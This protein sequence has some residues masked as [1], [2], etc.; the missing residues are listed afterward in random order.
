M[1]FLSGITV[2]CFIASYGV[3]LA[4]EVV[5]L[6]Y[7]NPLR[8][9]LTLAFAGAG[10]F[11]HTVFLAHRAVAATGAPLSSAFDWYLLAAWALVIVYLYLAW[12]YPQMASGLFVL[13][14]VLGLI[15]VA[16]FADREPFPQSHAGQIWGLI[17]G[18]FLLMGLVTVTLGF[19]AGMMYLIQA[20][21]L[22]HKLPA[23]G[24][25]RLPSLE[26][27]ERVNHRS[28]VVSVLMI[29]IG[30]ASGIVLNMVLQHRKI[31]EVPWSDPIIW[32]TG[33]MFAWLLAAAVFSGVYRPARSGRKVAYLTVASFAVLA[34]TLGIKLLVPS[35]H[36]GEK[37][38]VEAGGP[39]A[40]PL[41]EDARSATAA[42]ASRLNGGFGAAPYLEE[43]A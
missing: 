27:L 12:Q 40:Q 29:G 11:A 18:L 10:L 2:V 8:R 21:R 22:K 32:T 20:Y 31:D 42:F 15:G 26:W 34:A 17:H 5:R 14:L 41:S 24:G 7:R 16:K 23:S 6:F 39:L 9:I 4:L 43:R 25:T 19:V 35:E 28:I 30:F 37:T 1:S 38:R 33:A 13:P 36:G 3:A